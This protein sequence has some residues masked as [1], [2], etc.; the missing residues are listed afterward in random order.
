MVKIICATVVV[1]MMFVVAGCKPKTAEESLSI[2][3]ELGAKGDWSGALKMAQRAESLSANNVPALIL[4]AV[5]NE[6]LG[7]RD[8]ALDVARKAAAQNPESFIAQYTLGRLY[9]TDPTRY[10]DALSP[11][12]RA[13][14]LC[15]FKDKNT[16]VLLSNITV[17]L[18]SPSAGNWLTHL[19]RTAP[20]MVNNAAFR[21]SMGI[22]RAQSGKLDLAKKEFTSAYGLDRS[23]PTV[24]YNIATFFDR[25]ASNRRAATQFYQ[26]FLRLAGDD[27]NYAEL[28]SNATTRLAQLR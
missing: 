9:A 26:A 21:N 28:K 4:C 16:L 3:V 1:S 13:A 12:T 14:K 15:D 10:S 22:V 17:A 7:E 27:A 24:L 23:N 25:Y 8:Q 5:A 20:D 2:G 18:R 6:K 11:L 19:A